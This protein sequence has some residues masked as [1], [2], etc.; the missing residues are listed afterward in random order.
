[1]PMKVL[2]TLFTVLTLTLS[3]GQMMPEV[4]YTTSNP[5]EL[6]NDA[7][8][9]LSPDLTQTLFTFDGFAEG[10]TSV[11][12]I[13][14]AADGTAYLTVDTAEGG[15]VVGVPDLGNVS[16]GMMLSSTQMM[17][18][19]GLAAPKGLQVVD[20]LGLVIVAD[21][22]A[23]AIVVFDRDLNMMGAVAD[24]GG[25]RS[26][27]DIYHD[28]AS[29]TLYAAGTDGVLLVYENF[30]SEMGAQGPSKTITPADANGTKISVNLHGVA[31]YAANDELI[32]TDVGD[33]GSAEDGQLFVIP[34]I[35]AAE[36]NTTVSVQIAGPASRLGNPVDVVYDGTHAYVAEKSNDAVLRFDNLLAM[37]MMGMMGDAAPAMMIEVA[38]AESVALPAASMMSMMDD[39]MMDD[40]M[41]DDMM[42]MATQFTVMLTGSE[43]VPPVMTDATGSAKVSLTGNRLTVSGRFDDLSSPAFSIADTPG[44]IHMGA[45]GTN[46]PP[47]VL[48]KISLD[49]DARGGLFVARATLDDAQLAAFQAGELY[50]NLHSEQHQGGELRA[51]LV[52]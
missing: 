44:H 35:S 6:A 33:A 14:F 26:V 48:L 41:A 9:G 27:W 37:D 19:G 16:E 13:A 28:V 51:Q 11:E 36:G 49:S 24:L 5:G 46:G 34:N 32:L 50:I 47:I 10:I 4:I 17:M 42:G 40:M 18:M 25:E 8:L 12:S 52:P 30:G 3:L 29:N 21:F 31:Y 45:V 39:A 38:K 20:D 7:I 15:A 22:G 1:M 2:T 23:N 43:E